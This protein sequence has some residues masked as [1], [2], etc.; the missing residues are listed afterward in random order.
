MS[1]P[2][3]PSLAGIDFASRL[4]Q[5]VY[6]LHKQHQDEDRATAEKSRQSML[7]VLE[8]AAQSGDINP[9]DKPTLYQHMFDLIGAKSKDVAAIMPHIQSAF[10]TPN[11]PRETP[12]NHNT[13]IPEMSSADDGMGNPVSTPAFSLP[14]VP[15]VTSENTPAIRMMNPSEKAAQQAKA[16]VVAMQTLYP[17]QKRL[18]DEANDRK[19]QI[20]GAK[21]SQQ[22]RAK[23]DQILTKGRIDATK[24]LNG[25]IAANVAAGYEPEAARGL[26]GK[27]IIREEEAAVAVKEQQEATG[28]A[29]EASLRGMLDVHKQNAN[30]LS[31]RVDIL[32][33]QLQETVRMGDERI[34]HN[35]AGEASTAA[36]QGGA[37]T[38]RNIKVLTATTKELYTSL[39]ALGSA[40]GKLEG[41]KENLDSDGNLL[42]GIKVQVEGLKKQRDSI[43]TKLDDARAKWLPSMPEP[44]TPE[45]P[46]AATPSG[47][48]TSGFKAAFVVKR[49]RQPTAAEIAQ[50]ETLHPQ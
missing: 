15:T 17:E 39:T 48:T 4:V 50:F 29:R 22:E 24:K 14:P 19:L 33:K 34:R 10:S 28:R 44:V 41:D 40:I 32:V 12:F 20:Q 38:T 8:A 18:L 42:P 46:Q 47:L 21:L 11:V 5:N 9:A 16:Q 23:L 30:T 45:V 43:Q 2:I 1:T 36:G 35:R 31:R 25:Y 3:S 37:A 7:N 27:Q 49:G 26:A 6:G 13:V